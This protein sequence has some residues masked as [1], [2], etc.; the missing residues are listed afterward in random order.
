VP[1]ISFIESVQSQLDE[2]AE[3]AWRDCPELIANTWNA[4]NVWLSVP[5]ASQA[6]HGETQ[7][8]LV[9]AAHAVRAG[10]DY[11]AA[12]DLVTKSLHAQ[13]A[14]LTRAGLETASQSAWLHVKREKLEAW[15]AGQTVATTKQIRTDLPF[16]EIRDKLYRDLSEVSHP[17]RRTA[18]FLFVRQPTGDARIGVDFTP[19]YSVEAV[20]GT[21]SCL[22]QSVA[23]SLL[24]FDLLHE[25]PMSKEQRSF[26][27][28]SVD[29]I[30][31]YHDRVL[32][33]VISG[34]RST[35]R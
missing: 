13:A 29:P 9:C 34:L 35:H 26:W 4:V 25:P 20:R 21:L 7:L 28:N 31:E 16:A 6:V 33:N 17:R 22:F 5:I 1:N 24:D 12:V 14:N 15:W 32:P 8:G 18:E 10:N 3:L 2:R 23:L 27:R 11:F 30:F 19:P